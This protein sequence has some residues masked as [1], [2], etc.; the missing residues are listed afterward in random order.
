MG[1]SGLDICAKETG[2]IVEMNGL[3]VTNSSLCYEGVTRKGS[4]VNNDDVG[5]TSLT[6][7]SPRET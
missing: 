4:I 6:M 2:L 5:I 3:E 7:S 1:I